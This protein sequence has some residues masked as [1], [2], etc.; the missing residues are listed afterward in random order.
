MHNAIW[1]WRAAIY[2]SYLFDHNLFNY[3]FVLF[4]RLVSNEGCNST[5]AAARRNHD[6]QALFLF[7]KKQ[8]FEKIL[9]FVQKLPFFSR[10]GNTL[11][12][13]YLI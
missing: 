3:L 11:D 6:N 10:S 7:L 2:F 8:S 9:G 1:R 5:P 4:I 13:S 12:A